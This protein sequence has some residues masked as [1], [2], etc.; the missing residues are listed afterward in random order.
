MVAR[1]D[2]T[3]IKRAIASVAGAY[4][5]L[6]AVVLFGSRAR[7]GARSDSD[8]DLAIIGHDID[9]YGL[10]ADLGVLLGV[11]VDVLELERADL[12]LIA[13]IVVDGIVVFV[14]DPEALGRAWGRAVSEVE[15]DHPGYR[16]MSDPY[17]ERA[18]ERGGR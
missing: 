16:R 7:G 17:L 10:G 14:R 9:V 4:P 5:G 2:E 15:L 12:P 3:A 8:V 1:L 13:S 11:T 6:S 18:A